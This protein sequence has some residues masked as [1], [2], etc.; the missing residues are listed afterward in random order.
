MANVLHLAYALGNNAVAL[1]APNTIFGVPLWTFSAAFIHLFGWVALRVRVRMQHVDV[2][3]YNADTEP[4]NTWIPSRFLPA[5]PQ[6]LPSRPELSHDCTHLATTRRGGN[7]YDTQP[8]LSSYTPTMQ[9]S[10][11]ATRRICPF[12]PTLQ[13]AISTHVP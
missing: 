8:M 12:G 6:P 5:V 3:S 10:H 13:H 1:F 2:G 7:V 11:Y 9:S 4:L